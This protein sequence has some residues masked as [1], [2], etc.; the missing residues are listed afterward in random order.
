MINNATIITNTECNNS[1][2]WCLAKSSLKNTYR[3]SDDN[4]DIALSMLKQLGCKYVFFMGGEHTIN[5]MLPT[6]IKK[7]VDNNIER[8]FIISNGSGFTNSFFENIKEYREI[9]I[10]NVSLHGSMPNIH[11]SIT[12]SEGSFNSLINGVKLAKEEKFH[13]NIQTTLCYQNQNDM[14]NVLKLMEILK[15][16]NIFISYC[17]KPLNTLFNENDFLSIKMFS[18]KV[19][20]LINDYSGNINISVGPLLPICKLSKSFKELLK[21][22][23]IQFNRGC[24]IL[25][26][27]VIVD[28]IGNLLLCTHLDNII[29]GNINTINNFSRFIE[30]IDVKIKQPMRKYPMKKCNNCV[31][32]K[33]CINGGC[34]LLWLNNYGKNL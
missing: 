29:L 7:A 32:K 5:P 20:N 9:I 1:C 13:I 4:F 15:V 21:E 24:G 16:S 19:A 33:L 6:F 12:C 11:D 17:R 28:A 18:E 31:D 8:I 10:L 27:E 34:P 25:G 3:M 14:F 30:E 2:T 23:R 22:N 26:H